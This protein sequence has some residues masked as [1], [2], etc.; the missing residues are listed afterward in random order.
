MDLTEN[1]NWAGL[2]QQQS[3]RLN[4]L[5]RLYQ[6]AI[7]LSPLANDPL[8]QMIGLEFSV[9]GQVD[10]S[11]PPVANQSAED[12]P[13]TDLEPVLF[14]KDSFRLAFPPTVFELY[15]N[16]FRLRHTLRRTFNLLKK[17]LSLFKT[18]SLL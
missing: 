18:C 17:Y 9:A 1:F 13:F 4:Q 12:R 8:S 14:C 3:T 7:E 11:H 5:N 16:L 15:R 6:R 10:I 2:S